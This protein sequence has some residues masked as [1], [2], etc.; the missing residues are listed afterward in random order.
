MPRQGSESPN[1]RRSAG[2]K[3]QDY[4]HDTEVIFA[5]PSL[6][7]HLKT[8][9]LQGENEPAEDDPKP[10]V[11][12]SFVTEFEDHIFVAMDAEA[13]LFLHDL[14]TNYV[15]E[16]DRAESRMS[17]SKV[18]RSPDTEK[19]SVASDPTAVLKQ[20][21]R[22]F[23]CQTWRLEP[24]VRL[25][26]WAGKRIDPVGVD[27]ILQKLGFQHARLTI[28]KWMQRG[29][30]DPLDKILSMLMDKLID[31]LKDTSGQRDSNGP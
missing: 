3:N 10:V 20:D 8:E 18:S 4:S 23:N 12:C 1:E 21:F 31:I 17:Y 6:Q 7:M 9:H 25:I 27:Y 26:S 29:A 30:M 24:T 5:L 19:K 2:R 16:K 15:K 13:I 11:Q 14:V 22:E 28:P